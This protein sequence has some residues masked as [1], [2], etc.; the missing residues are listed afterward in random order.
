MEIRFD[1]QVVLIT[2]ASTGIGAALARA[3]GAAG[4][5]VVVHYNSS[6]TA[7]RA[8]ADEIA[9]A[10][11]EIL[12]IQADVTIPAQIQH[13]VTQTMERYGRIDILVNNAGG[14]VR[15]QAVAE[16]SDELYQYITDLNMTSI[17][18]VCKQ[19][20]PIMQR[21]GRGNIINVTSIAARL[22][23]GAGAVVYA[24]SKGAVSTFTRGLAKELATQNIRVNA[25]SPGVIQTPFHERFS[26]PEQI[27][28]MVKTIPLGRAGQPEE[29]IGAVFFLASEAMSSYITG[30]IIEINGGQLMP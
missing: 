8:V 29:C 6:E 13:M 25:I 22:G 17:F 9:A 15:R 20:I 24:T 7:A 26:T 4:A 19:V 12:L 16:M 5:E 2:G 3:F 11:G 18:Q 10:G 1:N 27:E 14:L 23:G 28:A 21:Q 30:Q